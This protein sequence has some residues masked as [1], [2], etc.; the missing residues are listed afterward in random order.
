LWIPEEKSF[1]GVE[2]V[3]VVEP[4]IAVEDLP[5]RYPGVSLT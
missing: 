3:R 4:H 2:A 1:V 5:E